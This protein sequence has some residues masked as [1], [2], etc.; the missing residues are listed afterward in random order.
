[1]LAEPVTIAPAG[2]GAAAGH[3][4]QPSRQ[5]VSHGS[6]SARF[7]NLLIYARGRG[8]VQG[9]YEAMLTRYICHPF[10]PELCTVVH[11]TMQK[12]GEMP[13]LRLPFVVQLSLP[14]C[15]IATALHQGYKLGVRACAPDQ[16][17]QACF[18]RSE[19]SAWHVGIRPVASVLTCLINVACRYEHFRDKPAALLVKMAEFITVALSEESN[20]QYYD[21]VAEQHRLT[22]A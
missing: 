20:K 22:E 9:Y 5:A 18:L 4:Q 16:A 10:P 2:L 15:I 21:A 3:L 13:K 11:K 6:P 7:Q 1:M 12:C 17:L 19:Q 14:C 8:T